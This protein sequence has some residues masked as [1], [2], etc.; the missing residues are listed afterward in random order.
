MKPA[1]AFACLLILQD[2]PR[3]PKIT[4]VVL[5][6]HGVGYF[7]RAGKVS[8]DQTVTLSFKASQMK[9]LLTSLFAVDLGGGKVEGI[10]YDSK[11]P[12]EKQ[13][14]N[15]LIRV[16]EGNALTGLLSQLK[17][18]KVEAK[19]GSDTIRGT[20][21]GIEPMQQKVN[22]SIVTTHKLVL[23]TDQGNILQPHLNEVASVKI[24][25]ETL[26]EDLKRVL[27]IYLKSKYADR[28][29]VK[30]AFKGKDER[31]V[32]I[33][34]LIET[35]IWKTT[36]R[37]IFADKTMLQGYA[38][39]DNPTDEDWTNVDLTLVAGNPISFVLDLYTPHYPK[40]PVIGLAEVTPP[41]PPP[42]LERAEDEYRGKDKAEKKANYGPA[43]AAPKAPS[44]SELMSRNVEPIAQ[45]APVGE[46][47]A[48]SSKGPV[49]VPRGKAALIPIVNEAIQ[50]E[51]VLHV[52]PGG[53]VMNS[54]FLKNSSALTLEGGPVT[55]FEGSTSL[56][57]GLIRRELRPGMKEMVNYAIEA[58]VRVEQ[59][60]DRKQRPMHRAT[61]ANGIVTLTYYQLL[62]TEYK[63]HNE[64]GK[65]HTL[66]LDHPKSGGY[67]L[68]EPAK[69]EEELPDLYRLKIDVAE[70]VTPVKVQERIEQSSHV[71]V[72]D[73]PVDQIRIWIE[74]PAL[75]AKAKAFL[76]EVVAFKSE[77]ARMQ[78]EY[79]TMNHELNQLS[80]DESRYRQNISVLGGS[81]KE[82]ELREKY[83]EKLAAIDEKMGALRVSM[84]TN[85]QKRRELENAF[86]KKVV[87][88]K[89]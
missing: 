8:G 38:I 4:K 62:D 57:E 52:K 41:P 29:E 66:Y 55:V 21:M 54:F 19:V 23:Q 72:M 20:V 70:K 75:S 16:P 65:R 74:Q 33:G 84:Q 77:Q 3:P 45:G 87:E 32:V 27:E 48:Y 79:N 36:Y 71:Y 81:P 17:G 15:I 25:D 43:P 67:A 86:A 69:P 40:R 63:V 10:T 39:V 59:A 37:L 42:S 6:K 34:Y 60:V 2:Q 26:Q 24:L 31:D 89:D 53:R 9:D 30:I 58:G 68:L 44:V 14:E 76:E 51:R 83:L 50:G 61:F 11:D 82:R 5:Y 46:L 88:F 64:S 22:D 18:V 12:I 1:L 49:S 13:L 7:E 85:E 73:A 35:P 47:F 78:R 80:T 56:G 28:K